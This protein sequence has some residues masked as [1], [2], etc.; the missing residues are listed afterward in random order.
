MRLKVEVTEASLTDALE[1]FYNEDGDEVVVQTLGDVIAEKL[2]ARLQADDRWDGM[3]ARFWAEV[4]RYMRLAMP[5]AV[6]ELVRGEVARQLD[7]V[8]QTAAVRGTPSTRAEAMVAVEVTTQLA[9]KFAPAVEQALQAV[10]RDLD[11]A[12]GEA[13]ASFRQKLADQ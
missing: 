12:A 13:V 8:T 6:R 11:K 3:V 10:R 5:E 9:A 2:L 7:K 4:D 1:V